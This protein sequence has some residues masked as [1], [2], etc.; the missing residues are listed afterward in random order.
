LGQE[1]EGESGDVVLSQQA[2]LVPR[3]PNLGLGLGED[4]AAGAAAFAAARTEN[5][6]DGPEVSGELCGVVEG[7]SGT[8]AGARGRRV[9]LRP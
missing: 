4:V 8:L 5:G 7:M 1:I 3:A 2:D 9:T 6:R